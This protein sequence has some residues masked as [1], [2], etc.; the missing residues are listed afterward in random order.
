L[1]DDMERRARY[2]EPTHS[3]FNSHSLE[4]A[5]IIFAAAPEVD[6]VSKMLCKKINPN[7]KTGSIDKYREEIFPFYPA[8]PR[9]NISVP[10]FGLLLN[11]WEQWSEGKMPQWW[12]A[13]N[14]VRHHRHTHF[15]EANLENTLNAVAGLFVLLLIYYRDEGQ[16]GQLKPTPRFFRAGHPFQVGTNVFEASET[17]Y[18]FVDN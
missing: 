8:I 12:D 11:P 17:I 13:Y 3:N 1:D 7:S 16:N 15:A 2:L 10:R 18:T 14:N 5:R 9:I 4:L 6:V